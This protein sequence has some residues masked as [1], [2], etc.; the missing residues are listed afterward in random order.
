MTGLAHTQTST[1]TSNPVVLLSSPADIEDVY[2][3]IE[4]DMRAVNALIHNRLQSEVPLISQVGGYIIKNG[5]KRLRP[6][7]ALLGARAFGYQGTQHIDVAAIIEFIHT[8]TLLHDDVVDTSEMR[9]GKETAN[10]LWGNQASIL[11]GDFLYSRAFEMMVEVS[12]MRVLKI[13]AHTTNTIAE[14]EILQLLNCRD[15]DTTEQRYLNVIRCKTA[16][17][18]EAAAQLGGL[19][20]ACTREQQQSL[21]R[22]G[23]HLG[24][25]FQLRDDVL[26][27]S[28]SPEKIGK[29]IGDD[30]AEGKPTLPLIYAMHTGTTQQADIIRKAIESSG[31]EEIENVTRAIESTNAI[32]YTSSVAQQ[33]AHK[34]T[35]ALSILA[36]SAYKEALRTLANFSAHRNY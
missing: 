17:L 21:A 28:A 31:R 32:A 19:I 26:D 36:D 8:A 23:M 20:G 15:P 30:L 3:L 11:V 16:K 4:D 9:R 25:A 18:F 22:Y 33:E 13:L 7:I 6:I 2:T 5:G 24:M 12:D 29:N 10:A 1:N 34:A 27:Y 35:A 14:G